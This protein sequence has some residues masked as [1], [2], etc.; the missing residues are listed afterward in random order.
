MHL[1]E[2]IRLERKRQ[3]TESFSKAGREYKSQKILFFLN[4]NL[5]NNEEES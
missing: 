2:I 5:L 1:S 4:S 3:N